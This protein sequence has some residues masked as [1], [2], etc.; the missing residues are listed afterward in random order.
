MT[1]LA[2]SLIFFGSVLLF[3][4]IMVI[5]WWR[6]YGKNVFLTIKNGFLSQKGG[7]LPPNMPNYMKFDQQIKNFYNIMNK[8]G[9]K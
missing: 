3:M 2:I 5:I 8:M 4:T 7:I 1:F 6:K 9:K